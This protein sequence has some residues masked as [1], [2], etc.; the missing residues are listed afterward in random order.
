MNR[1]CLDE[2]AGYEQERSYTRYPSL[3]CIEVFGKES[4]R[5]GEAAF[6]EQG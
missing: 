5:Y 3:A 4:Y 6:S 1:N 2:G